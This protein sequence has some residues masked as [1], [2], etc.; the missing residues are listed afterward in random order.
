MR[1]LGRL[2]TYIVIF[3]TS[4]SFGVEPAHGQDDRAVSEALGLPGWLTAH[5]SARVRPESRWGRAFTQGDDEAYVL[6]RGRLSV[7]IDAARWARFFL[8][9]QGSRAFGLP[10]AGITLADG[11]DFYQG[12][13]E[14]GRPDGLVQLRVGRQEMRYGQERLISVNP[15]RNTGRSFDAARV[16]VGSETLG[17]DVFTGGVIEKDQD[18][19][20]RRVEGENLHG[21]YARFGHEGDGLR[22]EPYVL[23]RTRATTEGRPVSENRTSFGVRVAHQFSSQLDATGEA[24]RQVG[25]SLDQSV[26]AWMAYGA[27][28]YELDDVVWRP[29]LEGEYSYASGDTD[30][31]DGRLQGFDT[32]Y[33]T[34]HRFYG[35]ADLI[36]GRNIQ[37]VHAEISLRPATGLSVVV[38]VHRFWLAT[39]MDGLYRTSLAVAVPAPTG[40]FETSDVGAELD[41]TIS[42]RVLEWLTVGGGW[43]HFFRGRLLETHTTASA[44]SFTY[45]TI[46]ARF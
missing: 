33:S 25:D 13:V 36:G 20:D 37:N 19:L 30:P 39:R 41:L 10:D 6:T 2:V 42:Y 3:L 17:V 35:Y 44:S 24:V 5:G 9:G 8:Q 21:A 12:Y 38:D 31:S 45:T 23:I 43:S 40:G 28:G 34:P 16:M 46:E 26:S 4:L 11:T 29:R 32:L 27:I 7:G 15:W 22:V 1:V 14:L 18:G